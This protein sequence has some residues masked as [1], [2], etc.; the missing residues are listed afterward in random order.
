M[1][2]ALEEPTMKRRRRLF[3]PRNLS[4]GAQM[5]IPPT[6]EPIAHISPNRRDPSHPGRKRVI[7][8]DQWRFIE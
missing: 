6:I 1:A 5:K 2:R 4:W 3:R 8:L 7:T